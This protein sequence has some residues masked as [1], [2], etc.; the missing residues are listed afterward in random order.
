MPT[1]NAA[2]E[3]EPK[4]KRRWFQFSLR[5]LMIVVTL[6]CAAG[7]YVI[8]QKKIVSERRAMRYAIT[9]INGATDG[10]HRTFI[11]L[12]NANDAE[13]AIPWLR[14]VLGDQ[15]VQSIGLPVVVPLEF[16]D[17]V[18]AMFLE[19]DVIAIAGSVPGNKSL[20]AW[21]DEPPL[22]RLLHRTD[23]IK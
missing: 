18:R 10:H 9:K 14:T 1:D 6:F 13:H 20:V 12:W 3:T 7:G 16:R 2:V 22:N 11:D 15:A 21:P 19:A 23:P 17:H 8:R 5:T 4:R